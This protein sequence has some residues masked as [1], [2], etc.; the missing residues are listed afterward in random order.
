MDGLA[1]L[2]VGTDEF[3]I[4]LEVDASAVRDSEDGAHVQ[5]VFGV[6][7]LPCFICVWLSDLRLGQAGFLMH[8]GKGLGE[9]VAP[10]DEPQ[11]FFM[12]VVVRLPNLLAA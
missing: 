6:A 10:R 9:S 12:R 2:A 4:G 11:I 1:I 3:G 8:F 5:T 7:V